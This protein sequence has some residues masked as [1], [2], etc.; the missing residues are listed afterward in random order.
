[1]KNFDE[2][3]E[4]LAA[5]GEPNWIRKMKADYLRTGAYPPSSLR[6]LLGDP[7]EGVEIGSRDSLV[8]NFQQK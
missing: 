5:S 2:M 8:S 7:T 6:R 1:M 3:K 4:K